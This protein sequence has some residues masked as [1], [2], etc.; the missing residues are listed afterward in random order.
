V[1][2]LIGV[3]HDSNFSLCGPGKQLLEVIDDDCDQRKIKVCNA[4]PKVGL[5][6]AAIEVMRRQQVTNHVNSFVV[7]LGFSKKI[8]KENYDKIE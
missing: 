3:A 6:K 8:R 4:R 1:F 2:V 5:V 7:D